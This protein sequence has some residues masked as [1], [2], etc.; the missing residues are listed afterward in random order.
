MR[1]VN[2]GKRY[3]AANGSLLALDAISFDVYDGE[4][5]SVIGP[6]GCGKTTLFNVMGGLVDDYTGE[7]LIDGRRRHTHRQIGMVFQEESNFP[8]RTTLENVA[9]PLEAMDIPRKDRIAKARHF[10]ELVGLGGFENQYPDELSGGMRQRA[11]L[12]R[13][14]AFEPRILLMDEP[15]AALDAQTRLLIGDKVLALRQELRQTM[16]LVTHSLNEAVQ[17]SDRVV[18]LTGR[19]GRVRRIIEIDLPRPRSSDIVGSAR[20]ANLVGA[21]WQDLRDEA[22]AA[23]ARSQTAS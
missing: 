13:A 9:F 1:V 18:V 21:I 16:L 6:S 23:M 20:F 4:I 3:D 2:V 10:I 11:A 8:W 22:N 7:V 17:L 14:L 19:P 12:A 5:I 15:F